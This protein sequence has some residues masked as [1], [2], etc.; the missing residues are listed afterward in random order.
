MSVKNPNDIRGNRTRNLSRAV[1]FHTIGNGDS[2]FDS[3]KFCTVRTEDAFFW[4][5]VKFCTVGF[6]SG[7]SGFTSAIGTACFSSEGYFLYGT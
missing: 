3:V 6:F 2:S 4:G 7:G 1:N 5:G